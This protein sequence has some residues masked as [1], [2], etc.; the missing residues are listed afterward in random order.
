MFRKCRKWFWKWKSQTNC[1]TFLRFLLP[2]RRVLL[3]KKE[4]SP[5]ANSR[6]MFTELFE[7][8]CQIF[9]LSRWI[10]KKFFKPK[11]M[12]YLRLVREL[13]KKLYVDLMNH[14][15]P[16]VKQCR[17]N[18]SGLNYSN[19]NYI[20]ILVSCVLRA[21]WRPTRTKL[22][23][24]RTPE[25][26]KNLNSTQLK[27]NLWTPMNQN[28]NLELGCRERNLMRSQSEQQTKENRKSKT[29][30]II[31]RSES[32][33]RGFAMTLSDE[34]SSF[35]DLNWTLRVSGELKQ[36]T[37]VAQQEHKSKTDASR[38]RRRQLSSLRSDNDTK[39]FPLD[40]TLLF[41]RLIASCGVASC[42]R[43][44]ET[45]WKISC[46]KG[47]LRTENNPRPAN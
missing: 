6:S 44:N 29:L 42:R 15:T 43:W 16:I 39:I 5:C 20:N 37:P 3:T 7:P 21:G 10:I 31:K 1:K 32:C 24:N 9:L 34:D 30:T 22:A 13:F 38:A 17:E 27:A 4:S 46:Q 40:A 12:R 35:G 18:G 47:N 19:W 25:S 36:H 11:L 28:W 14:K 8:C 26:V 23:H 2:S 33:C 41:R 45:L